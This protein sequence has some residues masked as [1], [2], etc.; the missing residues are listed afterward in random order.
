MGC[1]ECRH[2]RSGPDANEADITRK[3]ISRGLMKSSE[4]RWPISCRCCNERALQQTEIE[5][6]RARAVPRYG[7]LGAFS[8]W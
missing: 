8:R 5:L 3:L 4:R 7:D 1:P 6:S 2:V